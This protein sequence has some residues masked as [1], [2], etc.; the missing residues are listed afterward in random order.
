[1]SA[2]MTRSLNESGSISAKVGIKPSNE[3]LLV[4]LSSQH[5][6]ALATLCA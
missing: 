5:R 6:E 3:L 2:L 4:H 1:L